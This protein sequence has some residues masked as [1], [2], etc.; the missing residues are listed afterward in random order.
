MQK[1]LKKGV[2]GFVAKLYSLNV[3][4]SNFLSHPNLQAIIHHHSMILGDMPKGLPPK[5][6]HDHAIQLVPRN[7]PPNIRSY[8]YPY[9]QK[10]EI[11]KIVE[12]MLEAGII[13][14][15]QSAYSSPVVLMHKKDETWCM[16][17]DYRVLKK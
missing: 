11:E 8:R 3:S 15:S 12:E 16:C 14:H 2:D 5:R 4:Q 9:I 7:H 13:R 1:L 10:S 17:L 6:D